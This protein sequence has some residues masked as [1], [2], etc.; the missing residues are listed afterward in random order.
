V[1]RHLDHALWPAV[2]TVLILCPV[3]LAAQSGLP[4]LTPETMQPETTVVEQFEHLKHALISLP[5]ATALGALLALRPRRRGT[6]KRSS[7]VVQTQ[8][9]LAIIGALIMLVVG[10]SLARAFGVVGAAGLIRY[11][12]KIE[13]PKDA[14][15]ML[16]TLALGLAS[17]VGL[18]TLSIFSAGFI[19]VVLWIIESFE[20]EAFKLFSLTVKNKDAAKL[21]PQV[22]QL[23][24]RQRTKFEL[25]ASGPEEL[26][27][28]LHLPID[29]T[30]DALSKQ[31]G[32]LEPDTTV[33][34]EEKKKKDPA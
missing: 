4:Q 16:S 27:F 32:D 30:T 28:E 23:L 11:R 26:A 10:A 7:A 18:Y 29:R 14:G 1:T 25:R 12:A 19:V 22:E 3:L 5:L 17:G 21:Q 8:I 13:D 33:E 9:I 2:A 31:I 20:P 15:V 6:P 34:W 24:R